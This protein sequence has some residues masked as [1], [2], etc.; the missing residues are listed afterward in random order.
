MRFDVP[1]HLNVASEPTT[2]RKARRAR[3][4][5]PKLHLTASAVIIVSCTIAVIILAVLSSVLYID[6]KKLKQRSS[7]SSSQAETSGKALA[8]KV[9]KEVGKLYSLPTNE[10]PTV[11]TIKDVDQLRDQ[12]FFKNAQ[13]G[14]RLLVYPQ[15]EFAILYREKENRIINTGPVSTEQGSGSQ[16]SAAAN[17]ATQ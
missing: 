6:N 14:D 4:H 2:E 15:N 1:N 10:S 16:S 17:S 5:F 11:A 8:D 7:D 13:N 3:W 9:T 12:V